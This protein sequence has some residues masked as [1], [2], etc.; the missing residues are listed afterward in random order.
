MKPNLSKIS[1]CVALF[2]VVFAGC[3][4]T[5]Q[6]IVPS[7][8]ARPPDSPAPVPYGDRVA[9]A[10]FSYKPLDEMNVIGRDYDRVRKI[11]WEGD[12]GSLMADLVADAL[13][14]RG[15]LVFRL[16]EDEPLD[17]Y[18]SVIGGAVLRF[19]AEIRRRSMVQLQIEVTVEM[20]LSV[21]GPSAKVPWET[22]VSSKAVF[23]QMFP[24][25]EDIQKALSSAANSAADEAVRRL[26][27]R[28]LTKSL[29]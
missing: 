16:K 10:D 17:N 9:V 11:I 13:F 8:I 14:E 21:S 26:R 5:D 6:I 27:E 18:S 23:Q 25:P 24:G 19:E 2:A 22:S 20:N 12:P 28:G 7:R 15:V 3:G 4:T 29:R 1:L